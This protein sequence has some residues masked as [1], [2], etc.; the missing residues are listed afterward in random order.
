MAVALPRQAPAAPRRRP[1]GAPAPQPVEKGRRRRSGAARTN[2]LARKAT[3]H[4]TVPR[5]SVGG[6][7]APIRIAG[8]IAVVGAILSLVVYL[9]AASLRATMQAGELRSELVTTRSGTAD[10]QAQTEQLLAD[11]RVERAASA[12]GMVLVPSDALRTIR[13]ASPKARQTG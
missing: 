7:L 8:M 9:H 10:I 13:L 1:V 12:Y 2:T 5:A 11:G 6:R 4:R 3:I